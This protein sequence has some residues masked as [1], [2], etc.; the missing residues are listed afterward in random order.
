MDE[1]NGAGGGAEGGS[2]F[3]EEL[4]SDRAV[5]YDDLHIEQLRGFG[6]HEG[7]RRHRPVSTSRA[8]V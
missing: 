3:T 8:A 5:A 2:E 6:D 4:R 1:P 7:R